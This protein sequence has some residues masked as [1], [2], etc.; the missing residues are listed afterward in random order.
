MKDKIKEVADIINGS[1]SIVALTGAGVSTSAG[2]KD[3][4]GGKG[5]Y[6]TGEY[7]ANIFDIESFLKNPKIFYSYV[8]DFIKLEGSLKPTL[9]HFFLSSLEEKNKLK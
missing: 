9:S 1:S 8:R 7:P 5:I 4:R 2:I 6:T 3:F